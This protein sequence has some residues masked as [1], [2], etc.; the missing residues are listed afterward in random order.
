MSA[1]ATRAR[2]AARIAWACAAAGALAQPAALAQAPTRFAVVNLSGSATPAALL[3]ELEREV[4]RLH[5]GAE[6]IREEALRRLLAT[7]EQPAEAAAARVAAASAAAQ[8]G[9]C[10]SALTQ[11]DEAELL[12]LSSLATGPARDVQRRVHV[13]GVTCAAELGRTAELTLHARRLRMLVE[14]APEELPRELWDAHV[15]GALPGAAGPSD[16]ELQIDSEPANAQVFVN[17]RSAGTTPLSLRVPRGEVLIE[18]EKEGYKKAFRRLDVRE[19]ERRTVFRLMDLQRDRSEMVT[20]ALR[21]LRSADPAQRPSV[22][23]QL[24]QWVRADLLVLARVEA[25]D[26]GPVVSLW[27][28]D[29]ER[30]ALARE[31][32]VSRFD[33]DSGRV[34]ALAARAPAAAARAPVAGALAPAGDRRPRREPDEAGADAAMATGLPGSYADRPAFR[35]PPRT[36]P[37]WWSYLIAAG[38][39][40][41]VA[42]LVVLDQ[43]NTARTLD[44]RATWAGAPDDAA[45]GQ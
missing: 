40:G 22:L 7:A 45:G 33:P 23:A 36:R 5:A 3:A 37:P 24:A 18:V 20:A 39:V 29:A 25:R 43:P 32:I 2:H 11:L 17:F 38:V 30:G 44:F 12:A 34:E 35:G 31:V 6:P 13:L 9:D 14:T 8:A 27:Q 28:F 16:P 42:A 4:S 15:A 21:A 26:E 19:P 10:A 1:R 41:L